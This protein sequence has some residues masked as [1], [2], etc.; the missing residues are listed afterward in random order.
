MNK[1]FAVILGTIIVLAIIAGIGF[2]AYRSSESFRKKHAS[3]QSEQA[4]P[5]KDYTQNEDGTW[6]CDGYTYQYRL[7]ITG[8]MSNAAADSTFVYLSNLEETTFEQAW[9]A[10]GLISDS[11]DC[12]DAK[13]AVLVE[14]RTALS[15][16]SITRFFGWFF[17]C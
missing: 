13:D 10:A 2:S 6:T 5:L 1:K 14:W 16:T 11:N 8:R 7:E 12:F 4:Q 17:I 9:K 3:I 15:N